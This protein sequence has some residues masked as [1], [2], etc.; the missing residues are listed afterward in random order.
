MNQISFCV[1]KGAA[2]RLQLPSALHNFYS[3]FLTHCFLFFF[4]SNNFT[5]SIY[6]HCGVFGHSRLQ[7]LFFDKKL[8]KITPPCYLRSTKWQ[9][10]TTSTW[11]DYSSFCQTDNIPI[12]IKK[13]KTT[14]PS[15]FIHTRGFL[16]RSAL[17][18][19]CP[20]KNY[21]NPSLL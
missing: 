18:Y 10:S 19:L 4:P 12:L 16:T 1:V 15:F 17:R 21:C 6:S 3:F 5:V 11:S 9:I 14:Q 7:F 8:W 20:S 2:C 13:F